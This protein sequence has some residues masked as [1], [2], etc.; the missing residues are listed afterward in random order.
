MLL[1]E[2]FAMGAAVALVA[3]LLWLRLMAGGASLKQ[4]GQTLVIVGGLSA[5][6]L[7]GAEMAVTGWRAKSWSAF[8]GAAFSVTALLLLRRVLREAWER[9]PLE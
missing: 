6:F 9:F 4:A 1:A 5:A 7:W 3:G 2:L 8:V